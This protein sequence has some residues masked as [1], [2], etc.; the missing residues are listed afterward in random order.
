MYNSEKM[1]EDESKKLVADNQNALRLTAQQIKKWSGKRYLVLIGLE[2][3]EK[4]EPFKID[5]SN[6]SNL[7]DWLPVEDISTVKI[8]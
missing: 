7:D 6:Y 2:R 3:I 4:I 8:S 1:S 5:K